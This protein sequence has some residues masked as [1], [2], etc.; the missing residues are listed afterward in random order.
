MGLAVVYLT[1]MCALLGSIANGL[2]TL[3]NLRVSS[4]KNNLFTGNMNASWALDVPE[5]DVSL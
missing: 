1:V 2:Q 5:C 3:A 4:I